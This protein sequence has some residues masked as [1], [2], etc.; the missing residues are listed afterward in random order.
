MR[1][2]NKKTFPIVLTVFFFI[3]VLHVS[4]CVYRHFFL[5]SFP[6]VT[7]KSTTTILWVIISQLR[8]VT[9]KYE[10]VRIAPGTTKVQAGLL[11]VK[12]NSS[13]SSNHE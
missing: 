11:I 4:V 12:K 8:R 13:N 6:L 1:V 5:S 9:S 10:R 3:L 2:G 7:Y